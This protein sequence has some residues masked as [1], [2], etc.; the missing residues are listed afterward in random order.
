M[1]R[2]AADRSSLLRAGAGIGLAAMLSRVLGFVRDVLLA[3]TLGAGPVADAL[4]AAL[5]LP[6]LLRRMLSEGAVNAGFVPLHARIAAERGEAEAA[7]FAQ[8]ALSGL[9]AALIVLVALSQLVAGPLVLAMAAGY[10]A[11]PETY[12]L[13]TLLNRLALPAVGLL[14]LAAVA[15][16]ILNARGR[17][18]AAALAPLVVNGAM[19]LVLCAPLAGAR[20]DPVHLAM[21]LAAAFSLGGA[22]QLAL[23]LR[24]LAAERRGR[25]ERLRVARPRLDPEMRRLLAL[26]LPALLAAGASQLVLLAAFQAASFTPSGVAHLHYADRLF[27]LP[28]GLLAAGVGIAL[29]PAVAARWRAGDREGGVAALNRAMEAALLVALPA[30]LALA[31][32]A[33]PIVAVLFE[34]GAFGAQDRA[35]T[36]ATLAGLAVGLPF[37][38]AAKVLGQAL[39]A[40]ERMRAAALTTVFAFL[41]AL[42]ACALLGARWGGLGIGLGA[43]LAFAAHAA[44][45]AALLVARGEWAPDRRLIGRLARAT[46]ALAALGLALLAARGLPASG[47]P[48]LLALVCL[49]GAALYGAVALLCGAIRREDL[50]AL[51]GAREESAG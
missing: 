19:I 50:R 39:F 28:L 9:G 48:L 8:N 38:A 34:R 49:G 21:A 36:A 29:L 26:G 2:P 32:I 43:A 45:L 44:A 23:L 35:A 33:D 17:F 37:A 10:A 22:A 6:N 46:P 41:V 25:G 18:R 15:G 5:R 30:G 4:L 3:A 47:S 24:V 14:T 51:L 40:G 31:L 11:D 1:T 27:Q 7:R 42:A 12:A 13:A 16:A 20:I